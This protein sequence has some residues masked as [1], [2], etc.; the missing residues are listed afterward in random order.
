MIDLRDILSDMVH[1]LET[2]D[3]PSAESTAATL[4][5][6]MS[7]A[8]VTV[9]KPASLGIHGARLSNGAEVDVAAGLKPRRTLFLLFVN[10]QISY[11][12]VAGVT[13]GDHQQIIHSKFGGDLAVRFELGDLRG[14]L[15]ASG[16]DG[17]VESLSCQARKS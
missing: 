4:R 5:L 10:S 8:N 14:T 7:A 15:T 12:D 1:A 9:A 13:F 11:R 3:F 17:V 16:T 6:D 2:P